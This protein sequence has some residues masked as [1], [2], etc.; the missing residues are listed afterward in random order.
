MSNPVYLCADLA[1]DRVLLAGP[2]GRHA[3]T[4]RRTR[5]GEVVDLVD[6]LGTRVTGTVSAT[7]KDS[8]A[9]DVTER[10]VEPAPSP[11]ITVVQALAKGDRGE[12]AVELCTEVSV[13]VVVPWTAARCVVSWS[14]ERGAKALERW[15]STAR[16]AGK[17]SRRAWF[18]EVTEPRTT[19]QVAQLPGTLLVLHEEATQPLSRV[20]L[21]GDVVLV[22]G[23]E[24]GIGADEL[25]ALGGTP[26]RLGSSVLRTST[27]GA[28]AAAVVSATTGRW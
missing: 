7:T 20:E 19:A 18:P 16:E 22:V 2:E 21:S 3:A 28:A 9:V 10:V 6:G 4:V 11:R 23:P 26:V 5:V 8:L 13:D 12:L 17:Q 24:G 27:A 1:G 25:A 15:R 14:G